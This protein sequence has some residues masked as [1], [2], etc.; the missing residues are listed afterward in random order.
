ME[1]EREGT[2]GVGNGGCH[3][4]TRLGAGSEGCLAELGGGADDPDPCAGETRVDAG[5]ED[6]V[7]VVV[8]EQFACDDVGPGL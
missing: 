4:L 2:V 7:F 3:G 8:N 5:V 6:S 1:S